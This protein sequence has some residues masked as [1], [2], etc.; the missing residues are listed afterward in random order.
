L[1]TC[2]FLAP[3]PRT[4]PNACEF[5]CSDKV[6]PTLTCANILCRGGW[7]CIE[8]NDGPR[9][10]AGDSFAAAILRFKINN[11]QSYTK[12]ITDSQKLYNEQGKQRKKKIIYYTTNMFQYYQQS[13]PIDDNDFIFSSRILIVL[14]CDIFFSICRLLY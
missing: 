7:T 8:T 2:S 3:C 14:F 12:W 9:C 5:G 1:F 10:E 13:E 11:E 6:C 4:S